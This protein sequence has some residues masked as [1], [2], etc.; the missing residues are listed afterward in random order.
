MKTRIRTQAGNG[1]NGAFA[2]VIVMVFSAIGL[3]AVSGAL[4]WNSS[5]RQQISRT[6]QYFE[7]SAAAEAATE[8]VLA[9]FREDY[10]NGSAARVQARLNDYAGMV[11]SSAENPG[12]AN[13]VFT[14]GAG[15]NGT[16]VKK[17]K[18]EQY[19][20]LASQYSGLRGWTTTYRIA[21]TARQASGS[22]P[23]SAGLFQEVQTASIPIFQFAIF[24]NLDLEFHSMTEMNVRGRVHSNKDIYTYPSETTTFWEDVTAV[25]NFI[26]TRKPGDPDY[27]TSPAKGKIYYKKR[28]DAKVA[29]LTLPIGTNN[30]P[31]AVREVLLPPAT[32]ELTT[33]A[34]SRERYIN[35]AELVILVNNSSVEAYAKAPYSATK[36][37]LSWAELA[38]LV[39]TNISFTDQREGKVIKATEIDVGKIQAWALA[40]INVGNALGIGKA[41]NLI[42]V[43]DQRTLPSSQLAAV[44]L[45]NARILP[46]RGLT[47]ATPNPLYVLGHFNQENTSHLG[48]SNTT[49]TKPASLIADAVTVLSSGW[50]DSESAMDYTER[51][52]EN[53]TVNAAV[54]TGIVETSK[55]LDIYSGG[56]HNLL[57]FLE[58]WS[59]RTLTYNGS[60]VV[61]FNSVRASKPF[62]QPGEY[63]HPPER[64]INFDQNF[65]SGAKLPPGTPELRAIIRGQW[66][67]TA[68]SQKSI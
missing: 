37:S 41:P 58:D 34:I 53:M 66:V 64:N 7:T 16:S 19:V 6:A 17:V 35:K 12:W 31:A 50:K 68:A 54:L 42:Y 11:P 2:L 67:Q 23:I 47:V 33:S 43:Y 49:Y 20:D 4:A 65:T 45:T 14:D 3:M 21:S 18:E 29:S 15:N 8:K 57:R 28:H 36:Y 9:A 55:A 24:Y 13:F 40:N 60:M 5:N 38:F 39:K 26:K 30:S 10:L 22:N 51:R 52:A 61:L 32:A 25:G 44:R 63:Y 1:A 62:K 56:A 46:S 48:T 59:S 27:S